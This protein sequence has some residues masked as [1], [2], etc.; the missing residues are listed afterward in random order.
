MFSLPE[1]PKWPPKIFNFGSEQDIGTTLSLPNLTIIGA[2]SRPY[3]TTNQKPNKSNFN[4]GL[5]A[6]NNNSMIF[7][8]EFFRI[9]LVL[10]YKFIYSMKFDYLQQCNNEVIDVLAWPS[11]D[12]YVMKNV[13]TENLQLPKIIRVWNDINKASDS[14]FTVNVCCVSPG[15]CTNIQLLCKLINCMR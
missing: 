6:G 13:C 4:T 9:D 7:H 2:Q 8:H 5:S 3:G 14:A 12:F 10:S 15:F 1:F 11:N